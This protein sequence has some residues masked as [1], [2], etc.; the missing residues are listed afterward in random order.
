MYDVGGVD[1][2]DL[3]VVGYVGGG[4]GD[5]VVVLYIDG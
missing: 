4:G 1:V 3:V 2:D 5:V